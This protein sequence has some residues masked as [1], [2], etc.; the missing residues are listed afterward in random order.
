MPRLALYGQHSNE[1]EQ[2]F[3]PNRSMRKR[4]PAAL[5]LS[6]SQYKV[7]YQARTPP[8]LICSRR[9]V[10]G[11]MRRGVVMLAGLVKGLTLVPFMIVARVVMDR[12]GECDPVRVY[13]SLLRDK[14]RDWGRCPRRRG[15]FGCGV[16]WLWEAPWEVWSSRSSSEV[17]VTVACF[18]GSEVPCKADD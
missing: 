9:V 12:S 17:D 8:C 6:C 2:S 5:E 16:V 1:R 13:P 4:E 18:V 10:G 3:A 14:V 7:R 11:G 15:V